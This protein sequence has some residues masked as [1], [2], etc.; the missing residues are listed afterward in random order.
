VK[1]ELRMNILFTDIMV[2]C[3]FPGSPEPLVIITKQDVIS[4][5]KD[6]IKKA[7]KNVFENVD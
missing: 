1:H 6:A 2:F 7:K 4:H 5:L 3:Y